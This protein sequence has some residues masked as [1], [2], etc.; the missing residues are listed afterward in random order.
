[1]KRSTKQL[2]QAS[3]AALRSSRLSAKSGG[4]VVVGRSGNQRRSSSGAAAGPVAEKAL[5]EH[6]RGDAATVTKQQLG[7][8]GEE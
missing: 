2:L 8:S 6:E 1:M 7:R 3:A 4:L 5:A